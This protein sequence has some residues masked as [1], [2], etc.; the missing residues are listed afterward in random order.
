M[1]PSSKPAK[2][3]DQPAAVDVKEEQVEKICTGLWKTYDKKSLSEGIKRGYIGVEIFRRLIARGAEWKTTVATYCYSP[4]ILELFRRAGIDLRYKNDH[5][6][7]EAIKKE[8]WHTVE[9]LIQH[10]GVEADT[11]EGALFMTAIESR[12]EDLLVILLSAKYIPET[13]WAGRVGE[14]LCT[15]GWWEGIRIISLSNHFIPVV[16]NTILFKNACLAG[17]KQLV[18]QILMTYKF[19][20]APQFTPEETASMD[21]MVGFIIG[22]LAQV[23]VESSP[24]MEVKEEEES[25]EPL[26]PPPVHPDSVQNTVVEV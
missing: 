26:P 5:V 24:E 2:T 3:E 7:S 16:K 22:E 4:T 9:Y 14:V 6:L 13:M 25:E 10:A 23:E 18:F 19:P 21:P 1:A 12:D 17:A 11:R 15:S 20:S 8:H